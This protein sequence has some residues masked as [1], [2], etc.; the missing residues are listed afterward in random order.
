[1]SGRRS[2]TRF[3]ISPSSEGVLRVVRDVVVQ[4]ADGEEF[5]VIDRDAGIVGDV[6]TLE[7]AEGESSLNG[8]TQ[9]VES[10]PVIIDG[11]VRH[12]LR[13]RR[14]SEPDGKGGRSGGEQE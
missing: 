14:V 4:R 9:V 2:Y 5:V 12:R 13:L 8:R 11:T 1:M 6:L 10:V 3:N 7:S